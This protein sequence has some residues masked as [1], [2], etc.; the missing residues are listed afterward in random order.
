MTVMSTYHT[1]VLLEESVG[2]LGIVPEGTYADLTFGGGGHSRRILAGLG[3]EGRLYA[4][5]QDRDTRA[6]CPDDPRFHYVESNFRVPT[7]MHDHTYRLGVAWQNVAYNQPPH[8]GYYLPSIFTTRYGKITEGEFE[9]TVEV[10]QPIKEIKRRWLN[11]GAPTL[12]KS[13]DPD[14]NELDYMAMEGFTFYNDQY[15]TMT[16][17]LTGTPAKEGD[18]K[19]I[20]ASGANVIDGSMRNDTI[21]IHA[22]TTEGISDANADGDKWASVESNVFADHIGINV[23]L[24]KPQNVSVKIFN[25]AG[26]V[27]F[28]NDY[29]VDGN[30]NINV[31]GLGHLR[32]GIYIIRMEAAD[33]RFVQKMIKR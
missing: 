26:A 10:G 15:L 30:A 5:D 4:F 24:T 29:H 1:P 32:S 13:I 31:D 27:V 2:L 19:F 28:G 8:L 22:T 18:Y 6:N 16:F 9:Q 14:G 33:G 21:V 23:N 3:P 25:T 12:L 7:L 11:S 20:I 17:S